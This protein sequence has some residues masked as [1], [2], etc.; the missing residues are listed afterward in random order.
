MTANLERRDSGTKLGLRAFSDKTGRGFT[1]I[2]LNTQ[3]D[4]VTARGD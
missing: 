4:I 1:L 3:D 2:E